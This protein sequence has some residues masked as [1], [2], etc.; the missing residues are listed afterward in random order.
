MAFQV[1]ARTKRGGSVGV[2]VETAR[3]ALEKGNEYIE[4]GQTEI[5]FR[6]H[7]GQLIELE[8]MRALAKQ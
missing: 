7:D 8:Q 3:E 5:T 1:N 4:D 6:G 2:F